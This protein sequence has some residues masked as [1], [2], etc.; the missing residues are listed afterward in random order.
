MV[1][2]GALVCFQ[3]SDIPGIELEKPAA[4]MLIDPDIKDPGEGEPA[5]HTE[6]PKSQ[7]GHQKF[8]VVSTISLL[9]S[10]SNRVCPAKVTEAGSHS[11]S[12]WCGEGVGHLVGV[13]DHEAKNKNKT[14]QK[15]LGSGGARL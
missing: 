10:C 12:V 3:G 2:G 14:K 7:A 4:R 8:Q 13:W 1:G 5:L 11:D 15:R 9:S 6:N